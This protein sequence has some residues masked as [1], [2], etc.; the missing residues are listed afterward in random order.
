MLVNFWQNLEITLACNASPYGIGDFLSHV[1][2]D[3][4][5]KPIEFASRTLGVHEK[6]KNS[7]LNKEALALIFGIEKFHQYIYMKS[8][9]LKTDHKPLVTIFVPGK[10][11]SQR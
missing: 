6:K 11:A 7:Q 3:G 8:S 9:T 4:K 10:K 2:S 1:F 5:E